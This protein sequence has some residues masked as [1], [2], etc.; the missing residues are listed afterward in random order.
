MR[1]KILALM[2]VLGLVV[3]IMPRVLLS[4]DAADIN[5]DQPSWFIGNSETNPHEASNWICYYGKDGSF[6]KMTA[7]EGSAG[8]YI[9]H[10]VN[11]TDPEFVKGWGMLSS[12]NNWSALGYKV[13]QTGIAKGTNF[14]GISIHT[15]GLGSDFMIVLQNGT[16]GKFYPLY[17]TV[18]E[19]QWKALTGD[20]AN[21]D[22]A[23]DAT[24][25][26]VPVQM[27][28]MIYYISRPTGESECGYINMV[29]QIDLTDNGSAMNTYPSADNFTAWGEKKITQWNND[30]SWYVQQA[31]QPW[32]GSY[33]TFEYF[34]VENM[35]FKKMETHVADGNPAFW[36][37]TTGTAQIKGWEMIATD[38]KYAAVAL[39]A[40][41]D[42]ELTLTNGMQVTGGAVDGQFMLLQ[43][44]GEDYIPLLSW[45]DVPAGQS[46]DLPDTKTYI[47]AG[48]IVYYIYRSTTQEST[49]LGMTPSV[50]YAM[51]AKDKDNLYPASWTDLRTA[52]DL[53]VKPIPN[54][55]ITL[56]VGVG[57]NIVG[58][59]GSYI[60]GSDVSYQIK[61]N[62]GYEIEDVLVDG[63]SIGKTTKYTF[64]E[65][66]AD[67][68]LE[69]KFRKVADSDNASSGTS[70]SPDKVESADDAQTGNQTTAK[71]DSNKKTEKAPQTGDMAN[72]ML[73]ASIL[74]GA[75]GVL[76]IG[77]YFKKKEEEA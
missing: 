25:F 5:G 74:M 48:N 37:D 53:V 75:A 6:S 24:L 61:A 54:Y 43:K 12:Q 47:K 4:V 77:Y 65:L 62:Q 73:W 60:E 23:A 58:E 11:V 9:W 18:G 31:I 69:A 13:T 55:D 45:T 30:I 76:A 7:R 57:G 20:A 41:K 16:S 68:T 70:Q 40:E 26:Q 14:G 42:G 35:E 46:V 72:S 32:E 67:H 38:E 49:A 71:L 50:S 19:W 1:K 36:Q 8:S 21:P 63:M 10:P 51:D 15:E 52:M 3:G 44:S 39:N 66:R 2:L 64:T 28:D 56:K 22:V 59:D 29:P 34:D 27:G 17:P 33:F